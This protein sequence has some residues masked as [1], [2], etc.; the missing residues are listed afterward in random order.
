MSGSEEL[1]R[2][3]PNIRDNMYIPDQH[4]TQ[5]LLASA[6][7]AQNERIREAGE[8][9]AQSKGIPWQA[10]QNATDQFWSG[11]GQA[12]KEE[13]E[14]QRYRGEEARQ[15][16]MGIENER[17]RGSLSEEQ[18]RRN[19][20]Y[21]PNEAGVTP[22]Q[23]IFNANLSE[24]I[25][26]PKV[27]QQNLDINAQNMDLTRRKTMADLSA[28]GFNAQ[29]AQEQRDQE[30]LV[31]AVAGITL[32][33][34][35]SDEDKAK[36]IEEITGQAKLHSS[37]N[38]NAIDG[39]ASQAKVNAIASMNAAKAGSETV[40][41]SQ[42]PFVTMKGETDKAAHGIATVNQLDDLIN[43]Y[44]TNLRLGGV[45]EAMGSL[46]GENSQAQSARA[47][48]ASA[49]DQIQP[50]L[51][52][53]ISSAHPE[54]VVTRMQAVRDNIANRVASDWNTVSK[55]KIHSS[56][57]G[58]PEY[59]QTE[60]AIKNLAQGGK[61]PAKNTL[62]LAP[63]TQTVNN[64][65]FMNPQPA[66]PTGQATAAPGSPINPQLF[67]PQGGLPPQSMQQP[68]QPLPFNFPRIAPQVP[69]QGMP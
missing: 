51:G 47:T 42:D 43:Q 7:R 46:G 39:I 50:G 53:V 14:N 1:A 34:K 52:Q 6:A 8:A 25:M 3:L 32:D 22:A 24:E 67:N 45:G 59:T 18:A 61:K 44:K 65:Q 4:L 5:D 68:Q 23:Q 20:L 38:P 66:Q 64:R 26:K 55:T 60:A 37:I 69:A 2:F 31:Q 19:M 9:Y 54:S 27:T 40:T 58:R 62:N 57:L 10:A 35:L 13:V 15:Q 21:T 49:A 11:R 29:T 56:M 63:G 33:G 36:K 16:G 41:E 28:M 17:M 30:R 12:R 48:F